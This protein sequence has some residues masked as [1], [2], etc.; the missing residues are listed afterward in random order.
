MIHLGMEG[1][2]P[3]S[4]I[5]FM[6][7][8]RVLVLLLCVGQGAGMWKRMSNSSKSLLLSVNPAKNP[9]QLPTTLLGI[10]HII[11]LLFT[12]FPQHAPTCK[13]SLWSFA[14]TIP[15]TGVLGVL[16]LM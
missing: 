16:P 11:Q 10:K 12:M 1:I 8:I 5:K 15:A 3:A 9:T 4:G 14:Y 6:M 7:Q 13:F 2:C